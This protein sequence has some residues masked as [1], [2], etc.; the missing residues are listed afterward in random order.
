MTIRPLGRESIH[1][2]PVQPALWLL[3]IFEAMVLLARLIY[4]FRARNLDIYFREE[5]HEEDEED[6]ESYSESLGTEG[7][8]RGWAATMRTREKERRA[9]TEQFLSAWLWIPTVLVISLT[10]AKAHVAARHPRI[11]LFVTSAL[12]PGPSVQDDEDADEECAIGA[13]HALAYDKFYWFA[14]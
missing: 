12:R 14:V 8:K 11:L 5:S 10:S 9:T 1:Q 4:K 2:F 13:R 7:W 6:T 3:H